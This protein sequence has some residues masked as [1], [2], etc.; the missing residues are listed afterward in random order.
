GGTELTGGWTLAPLGEVWLDSPPAAGVPVTA[1]FLFDVP[2][3][4]ATD[5]LEV[6]LEAVAAGEVPS[7]PLV[8]VR[9]G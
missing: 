7:V 4:F 1:G 5:T 9:E 2:V 6:S 3:R 8:E